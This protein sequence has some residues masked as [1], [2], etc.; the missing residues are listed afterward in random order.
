FRTYILLVSKNIDKDISI[1]NELCKNKSHIKKAVGELINCR[2]NFNYLLTGDNLTAG[3][4]VTDEYI[5]ECSNNYYLLKQYI[6]K[7]K[8]ELYNV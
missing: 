4:S 2:R 5:E 1:L 3:Q 8:L 7:C 6:F